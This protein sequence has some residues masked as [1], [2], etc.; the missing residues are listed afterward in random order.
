MLQSSLSEFFETRCLPRLSASV[1]Y[2]G[3]KFDGRHQ[4]YLQGPC[5]FAGG[6]TH[7]GSFLVD[8]RTL[9]WTCLDHCHRGGQS[10]L[11]F[12]N[13]GQFPRLGTG[14]LEKALEK[15]ARLAE[16]PR[17]NLPQ[18]TP[19]AQQELAHRE[20][21]ASL[22]ETFYAWARQRLRTATVAVRQ[23]MDA[24]LERHGFPIENLEDV[25]AGFLP[26]FP[27]LRHG[28]EQA[29]YAPQEI[30]ASRLCA[31]KRLVGRLIGPIRDRY[32]RILSFWARDPRDRP[33]KF[34]FKGPWKEHAPLVGLDVA[35]SGLNQGGKH[36]DD[37]LVFERL[38]DAL[39]LHGLGFS[40]A[41]A[42]AGPASD[43]TSNRWEQLAALGVRRVTLA[44]DPSATSCEATLA[45]IENS[46]KA[47]SAP[48]VWVLLPEGS[49]HVLSKAEHTTRN[50]IPGLRSMLETQVV[51]AYHF[52]AMS[53][54]EKHRPASGWNDSARHAAWKEAI[55]WYARCELRNVP[56]LDSHFVP[57]IVAGLE[58]NWE[59]FERIGGAEPA[60]HV[61]EQP[62]M[63]EPTAS[64]I[65]A[66]APVEDAVAEPEPIACPVSSNGH[67]TVLR[68]RSSRN[69]VNG[70]CR[71]H[72]CDTTICFCFD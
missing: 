65:P 53:I 25:P 72:H 29:G 59:T 16:I 35:F 71:I 1:V 27:S 64:P 44:P 14:E 23:S 7:P 51:H 17:K 10:V 24:F 49:S 68:R 11:A 2:R 58:R 12:L 41:A 39:V 66:P 40:Q 5:P 45:A 30:E 70:Y 52:K 4:S 22:L 38:F 55:E 57:T 63:P 19:E 47:K 37:L 32:G 33:P 34:L 13:G 67:T 31:D 62:P 61:V 9:R 48:K 46:S 6:K 50:R 69:G 54:L 26:D 56:D 28:L 20:R 42:V 36:L 3:V 21:V 60:E 8:A 18:M 43:L 15:A